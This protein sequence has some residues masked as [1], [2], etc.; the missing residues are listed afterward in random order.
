MFKRAFWLSA[1]FGLGVVATR[2]AQQALPSLAPD[3]VAARLRDRWAA[4]LDE[5]RDEMARRELALRDVL[6]APERHGTRPAP[7]S[8]RPRGA[9]TTRRHA[10]DGR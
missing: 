4:A 1:G 9:A 5:G 8:H 10:P 2:K 7:G 6:A 3:N